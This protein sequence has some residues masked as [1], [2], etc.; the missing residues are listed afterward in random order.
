M[1]VLSR[2]GLRPPPA[3]ALA[4]VLL[5]RRRHLLLLL[6]AIA[7]LLIGGRFFRRATRGCLPGGGIGLVERRLDLTELSVVELHSLLEH[8]DR[9]LGP[10]GAEIGHAEVVERVVVER[11]IAT[12]ERSHRVLEHR[13]GLLVTTLLVEREALVVERLAVA[14]GRRPGIV[15]LRGR[16]PGVRRAF[17]GVL[18]RCGGGCAL[19][20]VARA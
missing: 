11:L 10:A 15:R 4:L 12:L 2:P 7:R 16:A 13:D 5:E 18:G 17:R 19:S 9:V 3:G 6:R 8:R 14:G 1:L 20:P